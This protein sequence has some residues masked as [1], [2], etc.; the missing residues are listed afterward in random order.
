M[1][2]EAI[3]KALGGRKAGAAWMARCPAHD[4]REPSLAIVERR[5]G[6]VLVRCH[7]G[8]DQRDVIAALQERGLWETTGRA[9]D[10]IARKHQKQK[11][12][13]DEPDADALK[14]SAGGAYNLAGIA[15]GRGNAGRNL[16]AFAQARSSGFARPALSWKLETPL[17]RRLARD[18]G[19]CDAW[20]H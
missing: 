1:T 16:F 3:A 9:W 18:G 12:V 19:T 11:R 4:D 8:C 10:R 20:G 17:G 7:A 5:E 2:A 14:R 6:K 15:G 13:P